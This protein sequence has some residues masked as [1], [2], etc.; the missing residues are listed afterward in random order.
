MFTPKQLNPFC[1][2]VLILTALFLSNCYDKSEYGEA[3]DYEKL[4]YGP[5]GSGIIKGT[6]SDNASVALS[7]TVP[8]MIPEPDGPY[9]NFS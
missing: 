1:T 7:G 9:P 8:L 3:S 2:L 6:V 5:S 4:G